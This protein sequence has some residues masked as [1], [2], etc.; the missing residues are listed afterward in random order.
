[1]RIL[2]AIVLQTTRSRP[3]SS[4]THRSQAICLSMLPQSLSKIGCQRTPFPE[5]TCVQ[6]RSTGARL[7]QEERPKH[8]LKNR[9]QKVH[10]FHCFFSCFLFVVFQPFPFVS[11]CCCCSSSC[12][13]LSPKK[14]FFHFR[15]HMPLSLLTRAL[16]CIQDVN[17]NKS[18]TSVAGS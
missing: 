3:A 2:L 7:H 1:M 9:C 16:T 14:L 5:R 18:C 6:E 13:S 15:I 10:V 17:L 8:H 4:Y 11:Y 12:S